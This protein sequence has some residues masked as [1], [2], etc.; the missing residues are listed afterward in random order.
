MFCDRLVNIRG[1]LR[2]PVPAAYMGHMLILDQIALSFDKLAKAS[3]SDL[4]VRLRRS[5]DSIND[6]HVRSAATIIKNETDKSTFQYGANAVPSRD[7]TVSSWAGLNLASLLFGP[8]L[9]SAAFVR[10]AIQADCEGLGYLMPTTRDGDVDLAI[11]LTREDHDI[12]DQD[13]TWKQFAERLG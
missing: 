10:R 9:G 5:L 1:R 12:I 2:P 3:L 4:A 7:F 11:S 13:P 8:V 6:Y